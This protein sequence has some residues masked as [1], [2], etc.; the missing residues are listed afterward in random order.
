MVMGG[1]WS[2]EP[3]QIVF[4]VTPYKHFFSPHL[5]GGYLIECYYHQNLSQKECHADTAFLP[6]SYPAS[7]VFL[8]F[9]ENVG[10]KMEV[11]RGFF[12]CSEKRFFL[13]LFFSLT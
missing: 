10:G 2:G 8:P 9:L 6:L 4:A 3:P 7:S 13:A 12:L 11:V 1:L 5:S